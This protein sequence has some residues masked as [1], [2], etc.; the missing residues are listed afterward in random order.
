[1]RIPTMDSAMDLQSVV[2]EKEAPNLYQFSLCHHSFN[3]KNAVMTDLKEDG[4]VCVSTLA[5]LC[6]TPGCIA[7]K[8]MFHLAVKTNHDL[9]IFHDKFCICFYFGFLSVQHF[10]NP[11]FSQP[12][13]DSQLPSFFLFQLSANQNTGNELLPILSLYL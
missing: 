5:R 8:Y 10:P 9:V 11:L 12:S 6:I 13:L 4:N 2:L 1:M 3:G 7:N